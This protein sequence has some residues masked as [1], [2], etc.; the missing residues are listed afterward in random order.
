MSEDIQLDS[1]D[2]ITIGTVGPPGER[3]FHFQARQDTVLVTLTLEKFQAAAIAESV[4]TL[5]DEVQ[6][7]YSIPT[8]DPNL[9]GRDLDL[10][11]PI[12]PAFRVGQIG[13]GYDAEDDLI[14]LVLSELLPEDSLSEPRSARVGAT[15]EQMRVLAAHALAVVAQGRPICGNCGQAIDAEGHFCPKSNGHR[16]PVAWA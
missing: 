3:V 1:A 8:P 14:Y 11:E 10:L 4:G 7:Q 2:F 5:L 16:K 13:I 9:G 12:L 6:K 15:R